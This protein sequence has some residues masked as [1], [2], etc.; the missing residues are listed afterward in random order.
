ML[1]LSC[2]ASFQA[3]V[4]SNDNGNHD[5]LCCVLPTGPQME[6][7]RL[8]WAE[9]LLPGCLGGGWR[10]ALAYLAWCPTHGAAAAEALMEALPVGGGAIQ[11]SH[12][13]I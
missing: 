8:A 6:Y 2:T 9:T 7:F 13:H 1:R 4:A 12:R 5:R 3:S 11:A 10:L